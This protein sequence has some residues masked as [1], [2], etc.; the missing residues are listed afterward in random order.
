MKKSRITMDT[1]IRVIVADD[2]PIVREGIC[3]C[4][5]RDRRI[6]VVA[7]ASDANSLAT[8]IADIPCDLVLSDIGMQGVNGESNAIAFLKRLVRQVPRPYVVAVTMIAHPQMIAGLFH[9]GVDGVV[10]KRDTVQSL[11]E[12]ITAITGGRRFAS[13][14]AWEVLSAVQDGASAGAGTLSAREWDVFRLYASGMTIP[15]IAREFGRSSKTVATQRR[16]AMR[17]LGLRSELELIA[18]LQQI[19]LA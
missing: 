17:K 13:P 14:H 4:L 12:A 18:Y 15:E 19:G 16:C 7:T 3:A 5:R 2:H 11:S 8:Q 9:L 10:D 6:D 1:K